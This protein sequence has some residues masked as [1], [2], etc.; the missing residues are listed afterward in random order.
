MKEAFDVLDSIVHQMSIRILDQEFMFFHYS[1]SGINH[2]GLKPPVFP[3]YLCDKN[4]SLNDRYIV[5]CNG[6][7]CPFTRFQRDDNVKLDLWRDFLD[8]A[9]VKILGHRYGQK[10]SNRTAPWK[11]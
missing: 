4:R 6:S 3:S 2:I 5:H 10:I 1:G 7:I 8:E 11:I 9:V